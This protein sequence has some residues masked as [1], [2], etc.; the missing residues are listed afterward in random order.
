[1]QHL[2]QKFEH[3]SIVH[4]RMLSQVSLQLYLLQSS[5]WQ[6]YLSYLLCYLDSSTPPIYATSLQPPFLHIYSTKPHPPFNSFN[7]PTV[8]DPRDPIYS[9]VNFN[10]DDPLSS[11]EAPQQ[12]SA[13]P[14][15]VKALP[16][17]Q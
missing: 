8:R 11:S 6:P 14:M 7:F 3:R 17:Y 1:M 13:L 9:D 10:D 4:S 2:L 16:E 5:K 12:G 15:T